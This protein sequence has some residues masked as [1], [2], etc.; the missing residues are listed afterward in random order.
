MTNPEGGANGA[1]NG[2]N[3]RRVGPTQADQHV[4]RR[5]RERRVQLGLSLGQLAVRLGVTAQQVAKY[6][7]GRN[8]IPVHR[9]ASVARCL[10]VPMG[11][12][13]E[14]VA[15]EAYAPALPTRPRMLM[16]IVRNFRLI[17][18]DDRCEALCNA[19]RALAATSTRTSISTAE[20]EAAVLMQWRFEA[21]EPD[22]APPQQPDPASIAPDRALQPR[23]AA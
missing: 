3:A 14:G 23:R 10:G 1:R 21:P 12:L 11:W 15:D 19:A 5:L 2:N 17:D 20:V 16:D 7:A 6:E 8:G 9:L 22:A 18:D 4:G 13:F